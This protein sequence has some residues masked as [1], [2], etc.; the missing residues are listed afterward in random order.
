MYNFRI[1]K[2]KTKSN[3]EI[4][5]QN[6]NVIIGPNNCG[7]S[8]FL[9]DIKNI[10]QGKNDQEYEK[11]IIDEM[12]YLLPQNTEELISR[13][14]IDE[15]I[16]K[17]THNNYFIRN[18]SGIN[19]YLFETQYSFENYLNSGN[20]SVLPEWRENLEEIINNFR[21][22][23][24][25]EEQ[26][27]KDFNLPD[28]AV[29]HER[30]YAEYEENGEK[31]VVDISGCGRPITIPKG[32][33]IKRFIETYGSLFMNYLGTEEKLLLCKKQKSYG[34]EDQETN[35]LSE[36]QFDMGVLNTMANYT[37]RLFGKDIYLD[38]FT[39]GSNL[40]FRVGRDFDF[41][42]N[43]DRAD[44][45]AERELRRFKILDN[46]GDGIKG[47]VTNY[48]TLNINNKNILLLD[49]PESFLH[50]PLARQLGEIIGEAENDDKQIFVATHSVE[51]LK[52]ILSKATNVNIVRI[53]RT[54]ED[55]NEIIPMDKILLHKIMED[56]LLKVSRVMEGLF[57]EKVVITEGETDELIY[58]ELIE[59]I[60]PQSGLYFAHGQNKQTSVK[61]A[62]LYKALGIGYEIISDF[63]AIR[64]PSEF[65]DLLKLVSED[66]R[67]IQRIKS[68]SEVLR[69]IVDESAD[70]EGLSEE[71][72]NKV[73]K[74]RRDKVYHEQGVSFFDN[75]M[76]RKIKE[77]LTMLSDGHIHILESGELETILVP[78]GIPYNKDKKKWILPAI[79][80]LEDLRK[81]D[82]REDSFL[83][84]FL[85]KVVTNPH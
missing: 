79:T 75:D 9:K 22:D 7:K 11:V 45:D 5:P 21:E 48:L 54:Q 62:S 31:K 49:E 58:Q 59:K 17:G 29:I 67:E 68:Y 77:T 23:I 39:G 52:G 14:G 36:V 70:I 65:K 60:F 6:I 1:E 85:N 63:D 4:E 42:R 64:V 27:K 82:I 66:E 57:C 2:I 8:Q 32:D 15:K 76:Q 46:E 41:I 44:S 35:F 30:M 56:P 16:F 53:T 28:S 25:V 37:K 38:R 50:P 55:R 3:Q 74:E 33:S 78:Y 40:V 10:L 20:V 83:Y 69:D 80:K 81:E 47:F 43:A 24:T 61:I 84:E 19:N 51:L 72:A 12:E 18:F 71:D 73:K 13:Y 26:I 34:L